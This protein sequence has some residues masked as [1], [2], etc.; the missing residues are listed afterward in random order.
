MTRDDLIL[1]ALC[2]RQPWPSGMIRVSVDDLAD[3][4]EAELSHEEIHLTIVG[5][6][7]PEEPPFCLA[8]S[9]ESARTLARELADA[10]QKRTE[11]SGGAK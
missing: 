9:C 6:G 7:G 10:I 11:G 5:T 2:D 4:H 1:A 3:L 8:L